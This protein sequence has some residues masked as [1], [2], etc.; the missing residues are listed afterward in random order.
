MGGKYILFGVNSRLYSLS[1]NLVCCG[2][3][4][5]INFGQSFH[6]G[7][8]DPK[9]ERRHVERPPGSSVNQKVIA[10]TDVAGRKPQ[11]QPGGASSAF[12]SLQQKPEA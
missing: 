6:S 3:E 1:K 11:R 5:G 10:V 4:N 8:L 7:M 2:T 12:S 9:G